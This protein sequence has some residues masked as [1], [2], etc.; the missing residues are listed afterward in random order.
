VPLDDGSGNAGPAASLIPAFINPEAGSA[1]AIIAALR[2]S[3]RFAVELTEPARLANAV[4]AAARAGAPRILVA[5]GDGSIA[6]AASILAGTPAELAV[7]PAGTLNH[8]ARD[9]HIPL[10]PAAAVRLALEG[11]ALPTDVGYVGEHLFLNTS[12]VGVYVRFVRLRD[13]LEQDR[14]YRIASVLAAFRIFVSTSPFRLRLDVDGRQRVYRTSLAFIGVGERELR[15]PILGGRT[16][17]GRRGLH[18]IVPRSGTRARLAA[19]A[20]SAAFRGIRGATRAFHLDSF[21]VEH[22]RVELRRPRGNV[23]LDGE[24]VPMRAPLDYRIARDALR[25]VRERDRFT[26]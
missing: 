8:F 13:R 21:I 24:V 7:A 16:P 17:E 9:H 14:S 12:S 5:G 4:G 10:D 6:T 20:L 25:V 19:S 2:E 18:V 22:C 26:G 1:D 15:V 3:G 23:A 11:A